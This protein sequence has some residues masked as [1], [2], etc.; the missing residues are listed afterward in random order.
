MPLFMV[1]W[2]NGDLSF[3]KGRNKD[4]AVVLLDRES[5]ANG[6]PI[7]EIKD[8][9]EFMVHFRLADSG[10]LELQTFDEPF[11]EDVLMPWAYPILTKSEWNDKF[12][13]EAVEAERNRVEPKVTKDHP[14]LKEYE[15]MAKRTRVA[16]SL[17]LATPPRRSR[18]KGAGEAEPPTQSNSSAVK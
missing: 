11:Q 1:R 7:K 17:R 6:C 2:P 13:I 18:R 16:E 15:S 14:I 10:S 12:P 4:D 3:V 8:A 9:D 5:D